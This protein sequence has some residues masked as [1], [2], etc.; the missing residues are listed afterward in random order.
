MSRHAS[1]RA[2]LGGRARGARG[3]ARRPRG[4]SSASSRACE[5]AA[6]AFCRLLERWARGEAEPSDARAA[7]G[8]AAARGR[9]RRDRARRARGAARPLPARARGRT[10]PRAARGTASPAR[11]SCVD[12]APVLNARRRARARRRASRRRTSSSRCS[13]ARSRAS[14]TRRGSDARAR[15]LVALGRPLRP[16]REP[17]RPR[18]GRPARARRLS[19]RERRLRARRWRTASD[20]AGVD[21]SLEQRRGSSTR[22]SSAT[23]SLLVGALDGYARLRSPA[24][25]ARRLDVDVRARRVADDGSARARRRATGGQ[26]LANERAA[27]GRARC[28]RRQSTTSWSSARH[29][30]LRTTIVEPGDDSGVAVDARASSS[31][32]VNAL[33]SGRRARPRQTRSIAG[34]DGDSSVA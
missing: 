23:S 5:A 24:R 4:G 18:G 11:P 8:G 31:A 27:A 12:W 10:A 21:L 17:A 26:L 34:R 30:Q 19:S 15:P 2:R 25:P 9:P 32:S 14:P 6:L 16:A 29:G 3:A 1:A 7:P 22:S 13:C 28:T 33:V 20:R